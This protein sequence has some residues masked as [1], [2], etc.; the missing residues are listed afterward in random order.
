MAWHGHSERARKRPLTSA[1]SSES[2]SQSGPVI[3]DMD[4]SQVGRPLKVR[5]KTVGFYFFWSLIGNIITNTG[6]GGCHLSVCQCLS[7][8]GSTG[9]HTGMLRLLLLKVDTLCIRVLARDFSAAH[10][11]KVV[12]T[13]MLHACARKATPKL[14]TLAPRSAPP[15]LPC[16]ALRCG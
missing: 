3:L 11:R 12:V 8:G 2:S 15:T 4:K 13:A 5:Y 9:E 6:C 14:Y 10:I 16:L 1:S 7:M